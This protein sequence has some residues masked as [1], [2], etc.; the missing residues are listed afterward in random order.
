MC[1]FC[2]TLKKLTV[3]PGDGAETTSEASPRELRIYQTSSGACSFEDWL[4][5]L[6]DARG[7]ARIQ[8]RLDRIEQGNFGDCKSVGGGV[9][10]L[11][12]DIGPDYRV[13]FAEDGPVIVLLLLGGE[14]ST[15]SKDIEIAKNYW[16]DYQGVADATTLQKL[17]RKSASSSKR[18]R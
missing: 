8:E 2:T 4:D 10:E 17:Q 15:Q 9:R 12:I 13:Y 5:A 14:K 18:Q 1:R 6:R 7:R 3:P 16:T 11:R